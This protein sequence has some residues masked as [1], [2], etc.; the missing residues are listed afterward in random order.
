MVAIDLTSP[1]PA[2]TYFGFFKM[3]PTVF[4]TSATFGSL[5]LMVWLIHWA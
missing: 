3:E 5:N 4:S 2:L 1:M